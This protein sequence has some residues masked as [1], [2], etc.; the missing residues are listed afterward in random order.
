MKKFIIRTAT[1][2]IIFTGLLLTSPAVG[3]NGSP[4]PPPDTH[5]EDDNQPPGGG[6]P[7]G[8]GLVI[9]LSLGTAYGGKKVFDARRRLAE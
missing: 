5:G 7:V 9:L 2:V 8:S 6:V 3:Q 4:P 1:M